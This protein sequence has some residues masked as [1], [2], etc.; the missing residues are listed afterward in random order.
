MEVCQSR[1][2]WR[3]K[4]FQLYS[5]TPNNNNSHT[6]RRH[7]HSP[8]YHTTHPLTDEAFH[9]LTNPPTHV[10]QQQYIS[11][12]S[13]KQV[14][15]FV[16]EHV[17]RAPALYRQIFLSVDFHPALLYFR[18]LPT[19]VAISRSFDSCSIPTRVLNIQLKCI[20]I[21]KLILLWE[22]MS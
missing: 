13:C 11:V 8:T 10:L 5:S 18:Y 14:R 15:S 4:K 6:S 17:A 1:P 20:Y 7:Q 12:Y 19:E 21:C 2:V 22:N 3:R 16:L 9:L